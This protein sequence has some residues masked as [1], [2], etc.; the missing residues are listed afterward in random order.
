MSKQTK[1]T[2]RYAVKYRL[3][4]TG[5]IEVAAARPRNAQF[6][7][8]QGILPYA[9]QGNQG[10]LPYAELLRPADAFVYVETS[11]VKKVK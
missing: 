1:N 11:S 6:Y 7:V 9:K 2:K 8:E 10:F 4:V 3:T 5:T